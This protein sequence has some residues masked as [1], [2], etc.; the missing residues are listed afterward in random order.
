MSTST[1]EGLASAWARIAEEAELTP[2]YE[3]TATP[4]PHRAIEAINEQI[5]ERIV[6]TNDNRLFSLLHLSLINISQPTRQIQQTGFCC[7]GCKKPGG[8]G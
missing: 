1:I 8:G 4:Q 2:D 6:A 5:R 3:G 7:F